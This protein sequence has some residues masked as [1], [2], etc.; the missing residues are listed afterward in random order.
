MSYYLHSKSV[1]DPFAFPPGDAVPP[2]TGE[3]AQQRAT[4]DLTIDLALRSVPLPDGLMTR[5]GKLVYAMS[6]ESSDQVDWLGC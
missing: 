5:L 3:P 6:D 4:A 2:V 1:F